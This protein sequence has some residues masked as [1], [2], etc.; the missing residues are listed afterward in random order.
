MKWYLNSR[1]INLLQYYAEHF[2]VYS[3][4]SA[5]QKEEAHYGML[6]VKDLHINKI[7]HEGLWQRIWNFLKGS[8]RYEIEQF[9][10]ERVFEKWQL[11][12]LEDELFRILRVGLRKKRDKIKKLKAGTFSSDDTELFAL[13][14]LEFAVYEIIGRAKSEQSRLLMYRRLMNMLNVMIT[15]LSSQQGTAW[16]VEVMELSVEKIDEMICFES[17]QAKLKAFQDSVNDINLGTLVRRL[18][19][20]IIGSLT[21]RPMQEHIFYQ[22]SRLSLANMPYDQFKK[23]PAYASLGRKAR[24]F[25]GDRAHYELVTKGWLQ[26]ARYASSFRTENDKAYLDRMAAQKVS[27]QMIE[28]A[29]RAKATKDLKQED[30]EALTDAYENIFYKLNQLY[31]MNSMLGLVKKRVTSYGRSA[32]VLYQQQFKTWFNLSF[33]L[34]DSIEQDLNN[35]A[36]RTK[37]LIPYLNMYKGRGLFL[38]S[39]MNADIDRIKSQIIQARQYMHVDSDR[40]KQDHDEF[41]EMID[42]G[43][44]HIE[45]AAPVQKG[46]AV[47]YNNVAVDPQ[48]RYGM[49]ENRRRIV[50]PAAASELSYSR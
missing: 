17:E 36:S 5:F 4:E 38:T 35:I 19:E 32:A 33:E 49:F 44:A 46:R 2:P 47:T 34:L 50:E 7:K 12:E 30:I 11:N 15:D 40:M 24:D 31:I 21:S 37:V 3:Q 48:R 25:F 29:V 45:G 23:S 22:G 13:K 28:Q 20:E 1:N 39:G 8:R 26:N 43:M 6:P 42:Q 14:L 16:V 27:R 41:V 18:N 9:D 10:K